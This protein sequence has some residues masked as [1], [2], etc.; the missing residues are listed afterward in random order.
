M[1]AG[2]RIKCSVFCFRV[3]EWS[4]SN[5]PTRGHASQS[6]A[7]GRPS[8]VRVGA[9]S[10]CLVVRDG[11]RSRRSHRGCLVRVGVGAR[12]RHSVE[13]ASYETDPVRGRDVLHFAAV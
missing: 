4:G 11:A 2:N 5:A 13:L 6:F 3:G 10:R 8:L 1:V 7:G 9:Q 12:S